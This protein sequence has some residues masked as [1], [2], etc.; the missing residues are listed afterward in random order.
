MVEPDKNAVAEAVKAQVDGWLA[1]IRP[2]PR[3]RV[4]GGGHA[5]GFVEGL[6]VR[7]SEPED[8]NTNVLYFVTPK[9]VLKVKRSE[10]GIVDLRSASEAN[11]G[12]YVLH[13]KK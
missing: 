4:I 7:I 12:D 3:E 13:E 1:G 8:P 10:F 2:F 11:A 5:Y 6:T 9:G